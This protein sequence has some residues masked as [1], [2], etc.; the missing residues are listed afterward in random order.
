MST[1]PG[2]LGKYIPLNRNNA[3]RHRL[4][5]SRLRGA[6]LALA[7]GT[8][9]SVGCNY[10]DLLEEL[11][12]DHHSSVGGAAPAGNGGSETGGSAGTLAT[13]GA[14]PT[15]GASNA[16]AVGQGCGAGGFP[17][18]GDLVVTDGAISAL[19]AGNAHVCALTKGVVDCWG[20]GAFGQLGDG[21]F[22]NRPFLVQA[23]GLDS[24]TTAISAGA[25][26]T[27]ALVNGGL[28][29]WGGNLFGTI[30]NPASDSA[31]P[32]PVQGLRSRATAFS[33]GTFHTCAIVERGVQCWG[34]NLYGQLGA[35]SPEST[36]A[37]VDVIGLTYGV[38]GLAAGDYHT[39]ALVDGGVQ[40]WG[41]NDFG[42]L[43]NSSTTSSSVPVQVQGLTSGVT[44]IAAGSGNHTCALVNGS[45]RCWGLNEHGQ[46]GDGSTS[47]SSVPVEVQGLAP[48]ISAVLAGLEHT[49]IL[50]NGG[51][52]CWG[53]NAFGQLGDGT[54]EDRTVPVQVQDL[55]S[56]V[57]AIGVGGGHTC[58]AVDRGVQC[59][60]DNGAGQL[61]NGSTAS[62][63]VPVAVQVP[64]GVA[65]FAG[66]TG[67]LLDPYQIATCDELQRI[68]TAPSA[69]FVLV[70]DI[71][72]RETS[73]WND[74]RGFEPI[75]G[76]AGQLDGGK[77]VIRG[78]T[79]NRP[80]EENVGLIGSCHT[81]CSIVDLGLVGGSIA[82]LNNVG[83]LVGYFDFAYWNATP[84]VKR[85][86]STA[87]VSGGNF[88][89]GL[90]G[91]EFGTLMNVSDCYFCGNVVGATDYTGGIVS[92]T[93]P[94]PS[95]G[96]VRG[97]IRSSYVCGSIVG[98][99]VGALFSFAWEVDVSNVFSVAQPPN[100]LCMSA[101]GKGTTT[102]SYY[103]GMSASGDC[104][105]LEAQGHSA[106]A[107][108]DHPVYSTWDFKA[109][110]EMGRDGL[111]KLRGFSMQ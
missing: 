10:V 62:S 30:G 39:C 79:I 97:S 45:V 1:Q 13:G 33:G 59:W 95:D 105:T 83:S 8:A 48:N 90:I 47:N 32:L 107:N 23:Q 63:L 91:N 64:C 87:S 100:N 50:A 24:G 21:H 76:F 78:L 109:V 51:V 89:A 7:L 106:F 101:Y 28:E 44:A 6:E 36:S 77:H 5:H 14:A 41:R 42:Q 49:C 80:N 38:T 58:A 3:S 29:C 96:S 75:A 46:L 43:G 37:P 99:R 104:G 72:C 74:G 56:G 27:C 88:V 16:G 86:F 9:G 82:G 66:G 85:V 35:D 111:P 110:W 54:T 93:Y 94:G 65:Q 4:F 19:V 25:Y 92:T 12:V 102:H 60:G 31:I 20:Y 53:Q 57:T 34:N 18:A 11:H 70:Q 40:C 2:R 81:D 98:P 22:D 68:K 55:T 69:A 67:T 26:H 71:D 17:P 108:L 84:T 15:G 73:S 103:T 61:G 52:K